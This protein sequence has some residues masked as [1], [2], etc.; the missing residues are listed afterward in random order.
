MYVVSRALLLFLIRPLSHLL[1]GS[2]G[3]S[4]LLRGGL[5]FANSLTHLGLA[6]VALMFVATNA[7]GFTHCCRLGIS[8]ASFA[9]FAGYR[10]GYP[11]CRRGHHFGGSENPARWELCTPGFAFAC[12]AVEQSGCKV[13]HCGSHGRGA[14]VLLVQSRALDGGTVV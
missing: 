9:C 8:R 3:G 5:L 7:C 10:Q 11:K 6:V 2:R 1:F 14:C 12:I 4:F 13:D